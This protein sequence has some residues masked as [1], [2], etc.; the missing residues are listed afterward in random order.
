MVNWYDNSQQVRSAFKTGSDPVSEADRWLAL[1]AGGIWQWPCI[2]GR[3]LEQEAGGIGDQLSL[4][5]MSLSFHNALL[6][7]HNHLFFTQVFIR[8]S[9]STFF[10]LMSILPPWSLTTPTNIYHVPFI[11]CSLVFT[12]STFDVN[13]KT[14]R[15]NHKKNTTRKKN[16]TGLFVQIICIKW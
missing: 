13:I 6:C 5:L 14:R 4:A 16:I 15:T 7:Q 9:S 1:K 11:F 12:R 2:K 10:S 3:W 8:H